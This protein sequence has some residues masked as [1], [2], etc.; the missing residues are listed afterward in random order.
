MAVSTL[1]LPGRAPTDDLRLLWL[2]AAL[3]T[4]CLLSAAALSLG[5]RATSWAEIWGGLTAYDPNNAD[6][7][8]VRNMRLPRLIGAGLAGAAL[9]MSGALIQAM[10]RNPLADPGLLGINGGAALGVVL[11]IL[12]LGVTDPAEFIWVALGGG[13]AASVLVFL[14]G[15]GSQANPL[16]L[17]LAGAAVSA[18]F[19]ALTRALL[20]VSRQTL[21]VYRFWVLGGFDGILPATLQSLLP[22]LIL[23]ALLAI[24]AG[25]GLNA[26]MLGEDTAKG[27]GVRTGLTRLTAGAAIVLLCGAT[28]AMAGPIAFAGLIVPH[29]ARWAAGPAIGWSLA[30]S[31]VFGALLLIAADLLGRLALFGGNMQ[32]GVMTA[33]IGG[34]VLIWLVR[35]NGVRK[36]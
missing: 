18:L 22:F 1:T 14:L 10:T 28:V 11:C 36:L 9:G 26:L 33:L 23:G 8:V 24:I 21:D 2:A 13:L 35:R 30:F 25:F 3:L 6:H 20:L 29:M 34:P 5:A 15:G 4:L 17:I 7:I 32:A 27:L 12:V 16:R 31:A 19:L